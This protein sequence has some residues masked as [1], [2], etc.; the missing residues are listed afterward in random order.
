MPLRSSYW[1]CTKFADM[2]RGTSKPKFA[3]G[4][5]WNK[6]HS[7]AKIKKIRY[8]IAEEGLDYLQ[9]IIY[10][11]YDK[12]YDIKSYID[13]RFFTKTHAL[14]S[15]KQ[16]IK[17]GEWCD[18]DN[19][20]LF[21]LFNELQ[22]HV[23][24]EIAWFHVMWHSSEDRKK[25]NVPKHFNLGWRSREAAMD[26]F[27]W[28]SKLRHEPDSVSEDQSLVGELTGQAKH[29]IEIRELYLWWTGVYRNRPDPY[30]VSGFNDYISKR[31]KENGGDQDRYMF[32]SITEESRALLQKV[33]E[34]ETMYEQEEEEMLIRL[35]KVRKGLWT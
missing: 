27:E 14:T 11:P 23:E 21:C 20:I 2:I 9:D 10:Y 18:L 16:D 24:C 6:W 26:Y 34:I 12:Y 19:R 3:T 15:S 30:E 29:A 25:Y 13:N 33:T 8:W 31:E 5:E 32:S 28:A 4:E 22:N 35:M 1:S 17:R 7:S